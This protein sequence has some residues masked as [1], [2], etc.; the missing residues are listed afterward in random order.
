MTGAIVRPRVAVA[1]IRRRII[2]RHPEWWALALSAAAWFV[3]VSEAAVSSG[4]THDAHRGA[5]ANVRD[6]LLM[7]LAMMLPLS[8]A[9]I[10]ATADRSLWRRRHQ[11]I[12]AWLSGYIGVCLLFGVAFV[13]SLRLFGSTVQ[14]STVVAVSFLIGAAWQLSPARARVLAACHR[15][16]PLAP[17]GWRANYDCARHGWTTGIWCS[18]A[19]GPL[20]FACWTL[21]HGVPGVCAMVVATTIGVAERYMPQPSRAISA[22]LRIESILSFPDPIADRYR[23]MKQ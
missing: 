11:A 5:T 1:A 8:V 19:C 15:P 6:W 18:L 13:M 3:L 9:A 7:I 21:G 16:Q 17:D 20:M 14:S 22:Y 2:W 23:K 4:T 10:Q 12:A